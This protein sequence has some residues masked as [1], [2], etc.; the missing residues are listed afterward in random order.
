MADVL[1][2]PLPRP[3]HEDF[4]RRLNMGRIVGG[5]RDE[6]GESQ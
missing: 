4:T 3:I 6:E 1:T 2:E 5:N